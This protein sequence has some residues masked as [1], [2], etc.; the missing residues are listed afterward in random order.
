[1]TITIT[2]EDIYT[3][4]VYEKIAEIYADE[5]EYGWSDTWH[6]R[7]DN[8]AMAILKSL[9][10]YQERERQREA[11]SIAELQLEIEQLAF[12]GL[13]RELTDAEHEEISQS[14]Q[15]YL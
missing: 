4:E 2:E 5:A 9:P 12:F 3:P 11:E 8:A 15:Q 13:D 10:A 1:M 7:A 14:Y 6:E